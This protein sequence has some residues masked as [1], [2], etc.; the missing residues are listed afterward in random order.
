MVSNKE[1]IF[2]KN[3]KNTKNMLKKCKELGQNW[4]CTSTPQ[5]ANRHSPSADWH[6][7]VLIGTQINQGP[8]ILFCFFRHFLG[9]FLLHFSLK[10]KNCAI[11]FSKNLHG[12]SN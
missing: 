2:Q 9:L 8:I 7:Q 10:K 1:N 11:K 4:A 6:P 5:S 3:K 12:L